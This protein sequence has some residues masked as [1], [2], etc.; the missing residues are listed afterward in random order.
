MKD[1][2]LHVSAVGA[3]VRKVAE[4]LE[5][6]HGG[7]RAG[8][9]RLFDLEA[10]HLY[11]RS[12]LTA[13]ALQACMQSGVRI[14]WYS[15]T[16][17]VARCEPE[18]PSHVL[19]RIAQVDRLR[20]GPWRLGFS[21]Q[22]VAAKV[23]AQRAVVQRWRQTRSEPALLVELDRHLVDSA[24]LA[25]A[26]P[27]VS[28]DEGVLGLEGM[29]AALHFRA[30]A[31]VLRAGPA[32]E[33]GFASRLSHPPG[34]AVNAALSFGYVLLANEMAG[35][36]AGVGLDPAIGLLHGLRSGRDSLA[37][38][39]IEPYRAPLVDGLVVQLLAR[40]ML[41]PAGFAPQG[42]HAV[43][44]T[45]EGR[46]RF[47]AIW[48]AWLRAPQRGAAY[49][50]GTAARGVPAD[51][52]RQALRAQAVALRSAIVHKQPAV[53]YWD[54]EGGRDAGIAIDG[55]PGRGPPAKQAKPAKTR[56]S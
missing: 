3:Q 33:L 36:L 44:L 13:A 1:R 45:A 52:W 39:A 40:K 53:W 38:D 5:V 2:T 32:A 56:G 4:R 34:D 16:R 43:Y 55:P 17:L 7:A 9:A 30:M 20:D 48:E 26:L 46:T 18:A 22:L 19:T 25:A 54:A 41:G 27:D 31:A 21:R 10:L 11:G 8:H 29:A 23:A 35:L 12:H 50:G 42:R 6:Y 24:R 28:T 47:L 15:R 37:L 14:C 51:S 49:F